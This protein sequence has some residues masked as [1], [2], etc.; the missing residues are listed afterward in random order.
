MGLKSMF[1]KKGGEKAGSTKRYTQHSHAQSTPN[2]LMHNHTHSHR[3]PSLLHTHWWKGLLPPFILSSSVDQS[4]PW[5]KGCVFAH[6]QSACAC[7]IWSVYPRALH[8]W[9]LEGCA[10]LGRSRLKDQQCYRGLLHNSLG[11]HQK[12]E[13]AWPASKQPFQKGESQQGSFLCALK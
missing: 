10:W 7:M 13:R 9:I 2:T 11:A 6:M 3:S 4:F 1:G 12:L 8:N 5:N